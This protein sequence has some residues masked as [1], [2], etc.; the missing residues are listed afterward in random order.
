MLQELPAVKLV[1]DGSLTV[2]AVDTGE[3]LLLPE[4]AQFWG[5]QHCERHCLVSWSAVEGAPEEC[6]NNVGG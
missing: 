3:T 2:T 1:I 4:A 6:I 5:L